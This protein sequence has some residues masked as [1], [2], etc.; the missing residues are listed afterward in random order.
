MVDPAALAVERRAYVVAAAGCGKTELIA[1][2]VGIT[3]GRSLVLTHT[4]AGVGALRG[5]LRTKGVPQERCSVETLDGFALR[6]AAAYPNTSGWTGEKP[7][8]KDWPKVQEAASRL[9]STPTAEQVLACSYDG[10]YVDEY[11]DCTAIQHGL[12]LRLAEILPTRV[13]GDPLQGIFRFAGEPFDWEEVYANFTDAGVLD[14]PHRW[15]KTNRALGEWLIDARHRLEVGDEPDWNSP[16]VATRTWSP[17]AEVAACKQ[18]AGKESVVALRRRI[19]DEHRIASLLGGTFSTMEPLAAQDLFN[20][21]A[22]LEEAAGTELALRTL[23]VAARCMTKVNAT[24]RTARACL[25]R[26]QLP[27][28]REGSATQGAVRALCAVVEHGVNRVADALDAIE[29]LPEV[30]PY[31]RELLGEIIRATRA[32]SRGSDRA[33]EDIAWQLR[34]DARRRGRIVPTRV[35]SR[36]LLVK[37]LEFDHGIVL[38]RSELPTEE[39]YVAI[40]RPRRS[41]TVLL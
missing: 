33:L 29:A 22:V 1:D 30:N 5:R 38:K 17:A 2:A 20:S 7:T 34:E 31:R 32:R 14:T 37:G 13:L 4:H 26:G 23:D 18:F 21:V 27:V 41:L 24:L 10:V 12:V 9:L 6:F 35:V 36:T 39:L 40:T 8:S 3:P 16:V 28:E 19:P 25:E 11:Q 15:A